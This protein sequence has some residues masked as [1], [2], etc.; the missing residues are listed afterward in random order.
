MALEVAQFGVT[1]NAICPGWVLTDMSREQLADERWCKLN[2]IDPLQSLE[3][4]R[5]SVP[6][7][8]FIEAEEVA[9]LT[10]FL[11]SNYAKGITGQSINICG[12]LSLR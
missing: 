1:V 12:G 4:A 6:Q 3:V 5:L 8:R 7:Q 10:V 11:C 2:G 9:N